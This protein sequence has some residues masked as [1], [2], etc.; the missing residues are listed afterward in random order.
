MQ[1]P[2]DSVF[3]VLI[4]LLLTSSSHPKSMCHIPLIPNMKS[5]SPQ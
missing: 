4:E 3:L 1:I 2:V 5:M